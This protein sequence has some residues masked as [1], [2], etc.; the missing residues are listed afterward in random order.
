MT[1]KPRTETCQLVCGTNI[2]KGYFLVDILLPILLVPFLNISSQEEYGGIF[3]D[4]KLLKLKRMN[5]NL[6]KESF[7]KKKFS[8][9]KL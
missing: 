4:I 3:A 6:K 5:L 8:F 7:Y 1:L 9:N 2:Y